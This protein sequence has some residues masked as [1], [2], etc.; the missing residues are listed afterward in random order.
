MQI[1]ETI[2]EGLSRTYK[3]VVSAKD[4]DEKLDLKLNELST[5]I[6]MPGF[7]PGKVPPQV[8]K[9]RFGRDLRAEI[10]QD[11]LHSSSQQ[12]LAEKGLRP[13]TQPKIEIEAFDEGKDLEYSLAVELMPDIEPMDFSSVELVRLVPEISDNQ[14]ME[15]L[16]GMAQSARQTKPLETPRPSQSGDTLIID[17]AGTVDGEAREGMAATDHRLELGSGEFV[18]TFEDQLLGL[19]VGDHASVKVTFPEPYVNAELAGKEAVFEVDVKDIQ[20]TVRPDID[21]EFAK[22]MGMENLAALKEAMRGRVAE[23]YARM[24]RLR[25]KRELL[26]RLSDGHDFPVPPGMVG[27]EFELIWNQFEEARSKDPNEV[28]DEVKD[29]SDDELKAEYR[30]IAERR[31]RLGLLLAEVG[32]L[33]NIEV[34]QEDITRAIVEEAQRHPGQEQQVYQ[35]LTENQE[36]QE[37]LRAPIYEDKVIDFIV[38]LSKVEDRAVPPEE[39]L[40]DPDEAPAESKGAKKAGAKAKAKSATKKAGAGANKDAVEA[41][42]T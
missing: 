36:A 40:R 29:K 28:A 16:Q 10:L 23:D 34:T 38:E 17:F 41:D 27:A 26:D 4:I 21:D 18:G 33:N 11:I 14:V 8:I 22:T 32:R 9:Q 19:N 20:E 39:I 6:K 5:Q 31:V 12:A 30:D 37:R 1:T 3:I 24:S 13:A 2:S 35:V 42:E 25:L 7:R 15:M